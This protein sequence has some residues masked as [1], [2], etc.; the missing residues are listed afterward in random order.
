[1]SNFRRIIASVLCV[2]ISLTFIAGCGET[3]EVPTKE[4]VIEE[5]KVLLEAAV[6]VNRIFFWEGLPHKELPEGATDT[7]KSLYL[8]L[9]DE[10]M[11]LLESDLMAKAEAVYTKQYCNDIKTVTFEGVKVTDDDALFARYVVEEGVMKIN[12]DLSEEGLAERL[13][14]LDTIQVVEYHAELAIVNLAFKVG[15]TT[16]K[17]N[18]TMRLE[19]NGWR[20]DTPTY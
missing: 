8:E 1:M 4:E 15:D 9:T 3:K 10:Y 20:L 6:E 13:P 5:A 18:V 19:E 14:Q 7:G 16:E 17:Q 12:R 2:I 11:F